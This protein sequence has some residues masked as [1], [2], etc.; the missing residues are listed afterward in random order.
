V[1]GA[2]ALHDAV[3]VGLVAG[4]HRRHTLAEF[5]QI[6]VALVPVAEQLEGVD[7]VL[8]LARGARP[9]AIRR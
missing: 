6:F 5:D 3:G 1:N 2:H 7:D 8:D 4:V 9:A